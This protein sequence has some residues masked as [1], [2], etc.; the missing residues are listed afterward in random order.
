MK[1]LAKLKEMQ[2]LADQVGDKSDIS[3]GIENL[4]VSVEALAIEP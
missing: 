4:R 2:E 3:D 1:V